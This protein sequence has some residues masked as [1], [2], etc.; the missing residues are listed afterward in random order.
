MRLFE[1]TE[2]DIP[3]RCERCNELVDDCQC[4]PI[5]EPSIPPEKQTL[6]VVV[7]KRKR[8][9][10]MTVVRGLADDPKQISDLLTMLKNKCGGG[11][12]SKDGAIEIQGDHLDR[13]RGI[14]DELGYRMR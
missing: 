14:L 6:K 3:P 11:G 4:E 8:G 7:E 12:T 9:K 1:G 13:I 10:V 2:F 5:P